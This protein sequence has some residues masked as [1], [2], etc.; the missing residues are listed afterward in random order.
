MKTIVEPKRNISTLWGKQTVRN[1]G[2]YRMMRYV[3]QTECEDKVLLHNVVTGQLAVLDQD[4]ANLIKQLP[5]KYCNKLDHLI[6]GHYLVEEQ[7]DEY[8][9]VANL[10]E[11]LRKVFES[12]CRP[13]ITHYT[14]LPTTAC[15]ARCYYCF[16]KGSRTLTMSEKTADSVVEFISSHCDDE[17]K[18]EISWFGGEPTVAACRIDR[19]CEGLTNKGIQ[20]RSDMTTNGY[21]F[22]EEMILKAKELW[23][24][25]HA[26]I[27]LDGTEE[28]YNRVKAYVNVK[29]NPYRRVLSSIN[30]LLDSGIT[31]KLRMNFDLGNYREF[32]DI[33]QDLKEYFDDNPHLQI[34]VHP[35]IGDFP[36]SGENERH[37][38][39][40]WFEDKICEL[41][42]MARNKGLLKRQVMLP[43]LKFTGC[44]ANQDTAATITPDGYLV[45]CPEQFGEDQITGN[46][47]DGITNTTIIHAWKERIDYPKCKQCVLFPYCEKPALCSAKD[48]CCYSKELIKIIQSSMKHSMCS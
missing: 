26:N 4:E 28:T 42:E 47:W 9:K 13:G 18:I 33:L 37:G 1:E 17:K 14:I 10:R 45:R 3:L 11:V 48:R 40:A 23:K 12:R 30:R 22:D 27:T 24:L 38:S 8:H 29:D 6:E 31:V 43:S 20:Y 39:E 34:S 35:I 15:N 25:H 2:T 5:V 46:I 21:L 7:Y 16:E 32:A 41:N 44:Q 36:E 19:I